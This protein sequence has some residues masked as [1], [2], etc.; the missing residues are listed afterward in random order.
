MDNDTRATETPVKETPEAPMP[1]AEQKTTEPEAVAPD[2]TVDESTTNTEGT[3]QL[4]DT[5]KER[6]RRVVEGALAKAK[7]LEQEL[8]DER[9]KREQ[10][11]RSFLSMQPKRTPKV[12]PIID[13]ITGLANTERV[14][15]LPSRVQQAEERAQ[16]AE[17]AITNFYR[18]Q[19]NS[20]VFAKHPELN[21][22][23]TKAFNQELHNLTRS[24]L[25]DSMIN[26]DSY[27]KK[28]LS[29]MEATERAKSLVSK[30]LEVSKK[31]VAQEVIEQLSPKEQ[32]SLDAVGS[33]ARRNQVE[34]NLEVLRKRTRRGDTTASIE[35]AK[36]ILGEA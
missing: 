4:P 16:R 6:T 5:A 30:G 28:Q 1:S 13:P 25:Y 36:R 10:I 18:E 9:L 22:N 31:E 35:R 24:I 11:E 32:A 19:E 29:F 12:E 7:V 8:R 23:D 34:S 15:E 20:A 27:G 21:P 26:P 2:Q 3:D 14:N 33:P 17:D